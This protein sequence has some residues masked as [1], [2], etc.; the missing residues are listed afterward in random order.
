MFLIKKKKKEGGG[1]YIYQFYF[2]LEYT[3]NDPYFH[4]S[5]PTAGLQGLR[6]MCTSVLFLSQKLE[7]MSLPLLRQN[8][9]ILWVLA[10]GYNASSIIPS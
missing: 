2:I 8:F 4:Q 6:G 1:N 5:F 7:P 9:R 3:N 10:L